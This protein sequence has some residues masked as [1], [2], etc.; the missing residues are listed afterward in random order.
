MMKISY[1]IVGGGSPTA[2]SI[3]YINPQGQQVSQ[4]IPLYPDT[5]TVTVG[6]NKPWSVTPNPLTP[7]T[8]S[9]RWYSAQVLSGIAPSGG[10]TIKTF[11]FQHQYKLTV[12]SP[13]DT[14]SGTGWYNSGA[15]AY[16]QL[17]RSTVYGANGIRYLFTEWSADATGAQLKSDPITMDSP[18]TATALWKTQYRVS[19][20]V[21]P[22]YSG[23]TTPSGMYYYDSGETLQVS[24]NPAGNH[25]VAW[26]QTGT[27]TITAPT[28]QTTTAII[29]GPGTLTANFD[30]ATQNPTHLTIQCQPS[31][32]DPNEPVTVTGLLTDSHNSPLRGKTVLLT[33]T[34]TVDSLSWTFIGQVTT[35]SDGAYLFTWAPDLP[36]GS[37]FV[38]AQFPGDSSYRCS[39]AVASN[40][41]TSIFVVP[42]YALGAFAALAACFAGFVVFKK[43]ST[44]HL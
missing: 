13:Y 33:Y 2:P 26:I 5:I 32:L 42:E 27:I 23:T 17:S 22:E 6:K 41:G 31:Q 29:N 25:F 36:V 43:R 11:S 39:S 3:N 1:N 24:A 7:S 9:E 28:S 20:D 10:Y 35:A 19:L 8:G 14:P 40:G 34:S 18:K 30:T 21:N 16:A 37:Y 44:L 4:T 38:M 15:T 12:T